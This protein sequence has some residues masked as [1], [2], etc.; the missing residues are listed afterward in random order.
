MA[1]QKDVHTHSALTQTAKPETEVSIFKVQ[2]RNIVFQKYKWQKNFS[3]PAYQKDVQ[4][5]TTQD[6]SSYNIQF[7]LNTKGSTKH[8]F[9]SRIYW[10]VLN[11]GS[12]YQTVKWE[13]CVRSLLTLTIPIH[14]LFFFEQETTCAV[15]F[16]INYTHTNFH[17]NQRKSIYGHL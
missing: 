1:Y 15:T 12:W 6:S 16:N 11:E 4:L 9:F 8:F 13:I 10:A 17:W 3:T 14:I 5:H 7:N 2:N